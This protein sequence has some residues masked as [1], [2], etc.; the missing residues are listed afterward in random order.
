ME[1]QRR[2]PSQDDIAPLK[3]SFV[4]PSLRTYGGK[5]VEEKGET[6][7][8]MTH[9][10]LHILFFLLFPVLSAFSRKNSKIGY[11]PVLATVRST[12]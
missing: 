1:L 6:E 3:Q 11:K 9:T 5:K 8:D 2:L 12:H 7:I 4:L 10:I